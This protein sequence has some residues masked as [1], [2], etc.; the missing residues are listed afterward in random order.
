MLAYIDYH[1]SVHLNEYTINGHT[2]FTYYFYI[3]ISGTIFKTLLL[4]C[5]K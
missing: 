3:I 4:L 2:I 1:T 5:H